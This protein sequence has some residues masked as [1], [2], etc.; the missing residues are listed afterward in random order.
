MFFQ[1]TYRLSNVFT[2]IY[3]YNE[4]NKT[5]IEE[6]TILFIFGLMMVINKQTN[7]GEFKNKTFSLVL[8]PQY[9][10]SCTPQFLQHPGAPLYNFGT[11]S[12]T[13]FLLLQQCLHQP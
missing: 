11:P 2:S 9:N 5:D 10:Q 4:E 13:F 1:R 12:N 7:S 8:T 6:A 3:K